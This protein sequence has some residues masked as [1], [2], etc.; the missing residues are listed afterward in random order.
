VHAPHGHDSLIITLD[1]SAP[2]EIQH[3]LISTATAA[4]VAWT[5]PNEF[6]SDHFDLRKGEDA[7]IGAGKVQFREHI[8]RLA[9][10]LH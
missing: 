2:P 10:Q 5:L 8:Q 3:Y 1:I 9:L 7:L 4:G 6:G